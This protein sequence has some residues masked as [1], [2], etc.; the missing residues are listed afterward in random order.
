MALRVIVR[1]GPDVGYGVGLRR[2]ETLS[3]GRGEGEGLKLAD[4][5]VSRHHLS[6]Q[7]HEDGRVR[8]VEIAGVN[9][10]WTLLDGQRQT[11]SGGELLDPGAALTVGNT[12]NFNATA[13]DDF[14][15]SLG[16]VTAADD[17]DLTGTE[18]NLI[19]KQEI[20]KDSGTIITRAVKTFLASAA[21]IDGT[22]AALDVWLNAA[23][24]DTDNHAENTITVTGTITIWYKVL[25]DY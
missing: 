23:I 10:V 21:I 19:A 7:L 9:P 3:V 1:A 15:F 17:N 18:V 16:T 22:G 8:V 13:N 12:T 20:D 4:Q 11:L 5:A 14:L 2:D 25:G 24:A 6:L